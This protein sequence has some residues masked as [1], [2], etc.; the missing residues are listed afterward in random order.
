MLESSLCLATPSNEKNGTERTEESKSSNKPSGKE[1]LAAF[2]FKENDKNVCN[3]NTSKTSKDEK[4]KAEEKE[5]GASG[6]EQREEEMETNS[7]G[8]LSTE[9][10]GNEEKAMETI[11]E[12]EKF[13]ET[14]GKEEKQMEGIGMKKE[15]GNEKMD[16]EEAGPSSLPQKKPAK[17]KRNIAFIHL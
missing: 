2:S 10:N 7:K 6:H 9:T 12:A 13:M 11:V 14:N 3:T 16:V 5:N 1:K 4:V 17:S 15:E 8:E